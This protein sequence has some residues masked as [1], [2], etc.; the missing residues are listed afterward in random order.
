LIFGIIGIIY[1]IWSLFGSIN[2][3]NIENNDEYLNI[4]EKIK[5]LN[6]ETIEQLIEEN[7]SKNPIYEIYNSLA[8]TNGSTGEKFRQDGKIIEALECDFQGISLME[9]AI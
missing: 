3:K 9:K 5:K 8:I 2:S 1:F 7:N 6:D 4:R